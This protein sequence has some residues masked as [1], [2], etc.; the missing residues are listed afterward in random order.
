[1]W[2]EKARSAVPGL[3]FLHMLLA[4][5]YGLKGEPE[6]AAAE[7]TEARKLTGD[8]RFSSI[9]SVKAFPGGYGGYTQTI[10]A[11]IDATYIVGLRKTGMPE[12]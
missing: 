9:A 6:R 4:S 1:M 11:L 7:L 8:D 12:E 2:L 5:A 10:R 3:P